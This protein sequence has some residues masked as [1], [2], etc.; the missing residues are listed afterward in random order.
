MFLTAGYYLFL[1]LPEA[2][3]SVYTIQASPPKQNPAIMNTSK[4]PQLF[5]FSHFKNAKPLELG[6][7][8]GFVNHK[9]F[10]R[11]CLLYLFRIPPEGGAGDSTTKPQTGPM[12]SAG[13]PSASATFISACFDQTAFPQPNV[14]ICQKRSLVLSHVL[15]L[16]RH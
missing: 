7:V 15:C 10:N 1:L 14:R 9:A 16:E 6:T 5:V 11:C 12:L 3:F 13:R 8:A 2:L 4:L